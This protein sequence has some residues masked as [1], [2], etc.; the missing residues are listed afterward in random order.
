M[1]WLFTYNTGNPAP[2]SALQLR[3]ALEAA[4]NKLDPDRHDPALH[5]MVLVGHSRGTLGEMLVST[6]V[7]ACSMRSAAL[8]DALNLTDE[9]RDPEVRLTHHPNV[10]RV[11]FIATPQRGS[12]VAESRWPS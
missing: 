11:I 3:T 12:F 10:I 9:S 5:N 6:P 2:I 1:S 4:V 8:L 7:R